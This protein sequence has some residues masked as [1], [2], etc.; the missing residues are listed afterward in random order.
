MK[1]PNVKFRR[2][3]ETKFLVV[4]EA[5]FDLLSPYA[6]KVY[7]QLRK[8]V[9]YSKEYDDVEITV[10]NL[11]LKSGISER[12]VYD[13]LNELE[14]AHYIIQ[15]NNVYDFKHGQTNTFSVSQTYGF[16]KPKKKSPKKPNKYAHSAPHAVPV[17]KY[18][19]N[20]TPT[21]QYAEGTAQ[22]AEGTAPN[23]YL[24][25]QESLQEVSKKKQNNKEPVSVFS[26]KTSVKTHIT[27]VI[28]KRGDFVEDGVI[29]QGIY[30]AFEKN[31]D[32]SFNSVN[33]LVN[34][35]LKKVRDGEWNIP[36]GFNG[37]TS[38]SIRENEEIEHAAK[39]QQYA[40]EAQA[41]QAITHS[42]KTGEG[43]KSLKVMLQ[44]YRDELNANNRTMPEETVQP[45]YQARG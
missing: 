6:I 38:Q 26:D 3:K 9:S 20:S 44:N 41:F 35:F 29:D 10:K 36:Q 28:A 24:I 16:F 21:A 27:Q 15:R 34:T 4:D 8:L 13:V 22:Y 33:K 5:V 25:E 17:D 19:Q 18:A 43:P 42:V 37:I 23:A 1:S 12:K 14:H 7:G 45:R 11:A 30:Y 40:Q 39:K 32:K 2:P 31:P